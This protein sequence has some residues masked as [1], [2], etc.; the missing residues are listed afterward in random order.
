MERLSGSEVSTIGH[1]MGIEIPS[2][3][4]NLTCSAMSGV[5]LIVGAA[6]TGK[7]SFARYL[8]RRL[9]ADHDRLA[10]VDGD[11]GQAV[12]GPPTTMTLALSKPND[13]AFPPAGRR[14]RAFVGDVSPSG[15]ML[16]TVVGAHRLVR[17][18]REAGASATVFDTT[19]LVDPSQGG[20]ALKR[21]LVGLLRP[22]VVVGLQRGREL[23]HLL[24][25]LRCSRRTRVIDL[26]VVR[27]VQRRDVPTRQKHRADRFRRYFEVAR[28]LEVAWHGLAIVPAPRFA[29][30]RLVALEDDEGFALA[31]GIVLA[32]ESDQG[33]IEL[34]TPLPSLENVDVV[35]LGDLA[36]NPRTF[37]DARFR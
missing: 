30:H 35:R 25:P 6:D 27:A 26:P 36:V 24:V 34:Y 31:L 14:F 22:E 33:T 9:G 15:H 7:T 32:G 28:R 13:D 29:P 23:E 1:Q 19:G 5:I 4:E 2:S 21:A 18:A 12:L 8:Y 20:G 37:H 10:F 17:K 11:M 3:W 16:P